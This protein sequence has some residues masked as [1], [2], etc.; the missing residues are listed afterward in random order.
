MNI[1]HRTLNVQHRIMYSARREPQGL[2]T[3]SNDQFKKKTEQAD[4]AEKA[5]KARSES[6]LRNSIWL[7]STGSGPEHVEGSRS[8]LSS[9]PQG[10]SQAAVGLS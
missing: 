1:E 9:Q 7:P 2:T 10:S 3:G 4:S 6:T 8:T 5:T